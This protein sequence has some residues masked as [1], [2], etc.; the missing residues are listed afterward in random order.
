MATYFTNFSNGY[1]L[2][3]VPAGLSR[4][5]SWLLL[6]AEN[7][8]SKEL[9]GFL[10]I[11]AM[12]YF[13][14]GIAIS[15]DAFMCSIEVITSKKRTIVRWDEEKQE[16]VER[17]ILIWN[18]TVANLTLMALGSSAPEILLAT[19]EAALR[20]GSETTEDSL[21]TFTIIGSAA[22][23]LLIITAICIVSVPTPNVKSIKEL[24]VFVLTSIWSI[25]A[26]VWMLLVVAY[27]SPN[28]VDPW[29][30]WLTLCFFPMF[31]LMAYC[32]DSG[33]WC[34]KKRVE[35]IESGEEDDDEMNVRVVMSNQQ[36]SLTGHVPKELHVLEAQ[37]AHRMSVVSINSMSK[38][39]RV[40][41]IEDAR[42]MSRATINGDKTTIL[43]PIR[44]CGVSG[45][46]ND[47]QESTRWEAA[48]RTSV[49]P[50]W[51]SDTESGSGSGL[52]Y[53]LDDLQDMSHWEAAS[54][55]GVRPEWPS[56]TESRHSSDNRD[57]ERPPSREK[58]I[59]RKSSREPQAF[60]RAR[61]LYPGPKI[62]PI[63]ESCD[64]EMDK[65]R[66]AAVSAMMGGRKMRPIAAP[67]HPKLADVVTK[68]KTLNDAVKQGKAP[69]GELAG[70]FTFASDRYAV[71]ESAGNLEIDVL[72]HRQIPDSSP[73]GPVDIV[74]QDKVVFK[75]GSATSQG[76]PSSKDTESSI[77]IGVV[78]VD[79]ETREGSAKP[80]KD[81]TYTQG[82]LTFKE[83]EYR[84]T[85][86]IPIVNDNQ[87]EAD[88]D[89]YLILKNP[90]GQSGLG[91]PSVARVTIV[92]DDEPGEFL[93]EDAHYHADLK[94]GKV[95]ARVL[96]EHGCDG[97]V[98]LEYSTIDGTGTG[99]KI[100]GPGVDYITS[101]GTVEFSHADTSK[102]IS[103]DVNKDTKHAINF[104]IALRNPS[105]G[106]RIGMRS[107]TVCHIN[108]DDELVER[109]ADVM[110]DEYEEPQ[111]WGGQFRNAMTV[112]GSTDDDGNDVP[113]KWF[114]YF[115][116][117]FTFFW[118][119]F[120][121][122]IPPTSYLGAWPAFVISL[123]F[124]AGMTAVVEQLGHLLGCVVGL[125]TSVTG[126]TI[127]ALGTSVPDTFASRTAAKQDEH[128][129]AAIGNVTGSNSVNVF[130][131]L[132]LPWVLSTMYALYHQKSYHVKSTNLTQSV[133]IFGVCGTICIL[134][135]LLRRKLFG[136]ELGGRTSGVKWMTS[137]F[138][139]ILWI[140][141]I[142]L[143]SLQAYNKINLQF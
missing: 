114:D 126:I 109:I 66:H 110:E 27:I 65:F 76:V 31:V 119:I 115:M 108:K 96:R 140:G 25:W 44:G 95:T 26:Y 113:P 17:E 134:L 16:K 137:I 84:K 58:M 35:G 135:L 142:I 30:A 98:K 89:F 37:K 82:K 6:P 78:S 120:C 32:Q 8:W 75:N 127:I 141:Y 124:I 136:G 12:I 39:R 9:R 56:D 14:M 107:A 49:R 13:F 138:L 106:A 45:S 118:K 29:E 36:S 101:S 24:G 74:N 139:L 91:D 81:F 55:A 122:L 19:I 112:G 132:G 69:E 92:D 90:Q 104:I 87:Y 50:E 1:V 128:A 123:L 2:E 33:W 103:V 62:S 28:V 77:H 130:L 5:E 11:V 121:A 116:H 61:V 131:G 100:L 63:F 94:D 38:G 59:V 15:S 125:E 83:N 52:T 99:G 64:L 42:R 47:L 129:D 20:L 97:K 53:S 51:L 48:N 18:E 102:T 43:P 57:D 21:G 41:Q 88:V 10:Y 85:F 133:I 3:V 105:L 70:K 22:F 46:L 111:T 86:S 79:Y 23:N 40:S 72:F 54:R 34:K 71:L 68:V 93:F 80:G 143:S 4:C 7:L 60:A 73:R 67:R 117:F